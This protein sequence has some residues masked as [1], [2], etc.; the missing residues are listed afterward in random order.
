[1]LTLT[2]REERDYLLNFDTFGKILLVR[3]GRLRRLFVV[4]IRHST[5][6]NFVTRRIN[7]GSFAQLERD[8]QAVLDL[9]YRVSYD[10]VEIP[11]SL[12]IDFRRSDHVRILGFDDVLRVAFY[13]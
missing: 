9:I 7:A 1:M 12:K 2:D 8:L 5:D 10:I 4:S 3:N 13:F 11:G 6:E